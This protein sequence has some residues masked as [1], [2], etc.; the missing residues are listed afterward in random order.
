MP[1]KQPS[2]VALWVRVLL[3]VPLPVIAFLLYKSGQN[4][5]PG[6]FEA[7]LMASVSSSDTA[8]ARLTLPHFL[9]GSGFALADT[10]QFYTEK[11]LYEKVD[12]HDNAFFRFGFVELA[13]AAYSADGAAFID[14]FAYRMNRR[15]N[16]LGIFAAERPDSWNDLDI[17]EAS[18]ESGGAVFFYRGP[19]YVQ[20]IPSDPAPASAQAAAELTD[21]LMSLI[22]PPL[23]A[24]PQLAMFPKAEIV[25]NSQGFIPSNA[26]GTDFLGEVFTAE[27]KSDDA[28]VRA[29]FHVSDSAESVF[30]RYRT[31]LESAASSL[32]PP[33]D[34]GNR[35]HRFSA[36][37]EETWLALIGD[38]LLGLDG[39]TDTTLARRVFVALVHAV[40]PSSTNGSTP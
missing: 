31:F 2:R 36:F 25:A 5:R 6:L 34:D 38:R 18:Y 29:F 37:G 30:S 24:I 22:P 7:G 4:P 11:N 23:D 40:K 26:F 27:Y 39:V 10:I 19:W 20:I 8:H 17:P 15:E 12:G 28:R 13:Y 14:L 35:I 9:P 3:Y 32:G 1:R 33:S 21:S 16:A